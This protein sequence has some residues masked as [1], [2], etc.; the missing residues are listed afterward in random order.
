MEITSQ[1]RR[2]KGLDEFETPAFVG[3]M[4]RVQRRRS[5]TW[6]ATLGGTVLLGTALG[7]LVF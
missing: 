4:A 2:L 3:R 6:Y 5:V 7:L 1:E